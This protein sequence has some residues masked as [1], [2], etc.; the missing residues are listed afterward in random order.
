MLLPLLVWFAVSAIAE[1]HPL[2]ATFSGVIEVRLTRDSDFEVGASGILTPSKR[3][4]IDFEASARAKSGTRFDL[5]KLRAQRLFDTPSLLEAKTRRA[6]PDLG[7]YVQIRVPTKKLADVEE[8]LAHLRQTPGVEA[9]YAVPK[10]YRAGSANLVPDQDYLRS[11]PNGINADATQRLVSTRGVGITIGDVE[12]GWDLAHEDLPPCTNVNSYVDEDKEIDHG[13]AVLGELFAMTNTFGV[14]GIAPDAR[15]LVAD[16]LDKRGQF[17]AGYAMEQLGKNMQAGDVVLVEVQVA[18]PRTPTDSTDCFGCL[19]V[20]YLDGSYDVIRLLTAQGIIVVE[21]AGN[22]SQNLDD[23]LYAGRF[24]RTRD[25]GAIMVGAGASSRSAN[26]HGR[27]GFSNYGARLDLQGFG[28]RVTT[29]GYGTI[30]TGHQ[31]YT[32]SFSGTSSASPIVAGSAAVV[33]G[34]LLATNQPVLDAREMRDLL[35]QTGT[36][37][38]GTERIGPLPNLTAAIAALGACGDGIRAGTEACDDG[39][40]VSGD[41]CSA[42]CSSKEICGNGI[43]DESK[44]ETCD[45][46]NTVSGDGCR[47]DCSGEES[48][49]DGHKDA[50][51]VCDDGNTIGGDGCSA[52]CKRSEVCGDYVVDAGELCDDGNT[53]SGDGCSADCRSDERCGNGMTDV[54]INEECDDGNE[55]EDDLCTWK[56]MLISR[57]TDKQSDT[58]ATTP[59]PSTTTKQSAQA[60]T[61]GIHAAQGCAAAPAST[62]LSVLFALCAFRKSRRR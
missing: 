41:G 38:I 24:S 43:V 48:C 28:E 1:G 47:F 54:V 13:T 61:A 2:D 18:G 57:A 10:H 32:H 22:G 42:D 49:G 44:G 8:M 17:S 37:Q 4:I 35:A 9:A 26:A 23:A 15:C 60:P 55:D 36:E 40:A 19:P 39:N 34:Y 59:R 56:C 27:L 29:T 6:L 52:D 14:N 51:E 16:Y 33:N 30:G 20:E 21:P 7:A 12:H 3:K 31:A 45:D 11:A 62:L 46:G 50:R 5:T 53:I 25:S 58:K